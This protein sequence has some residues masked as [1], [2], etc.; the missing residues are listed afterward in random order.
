MSAPDNN[1]PLPSAGRQV[2]GEIEDRLVRSVQARYAEN[3]EITPEKVTEII[4]DGDPVEY[5]GWDQAAEDRMLARWEASPR[6]KSSDTIGTRR[7]NDNPLCEVWRLCL[8]FLKQA[9]PIMLSPI[10]GLQFTGERQT[11]T[12]SD[13]FTVAAC[14]M[15]SKLFVHPLWRGDYRPF[16]DAL[17]FAA[18]CRVGGKAN[19]NLSFRWPRSCPVIHA[20]NAKLR[21]LTKSRSPLPNTLQK[22]H[23]AARDNVIGSGATES[24]FSEALYH[25][26]K[27]ATIDEVPLDTEMAQ[28]RQGI[29]PFQV[30]DLDAIKKALDEM[31]S[32]SNRFEGSVEDTYAVFKSL[33]RR[34]QIP[35]VKQL[36]GLDAR[37]CR[38]VFRMSE[39]PERFGSVSL[40]PD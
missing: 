20:L 38:Q 30:K 36:R 9:P 35:S 14:Q 18:F 3:A 19:I 26:G 8:R 25:I 6:K 1:A 40:P 13:L 31:A 2:M 23:R 29:V 12:S 33:G 7:N 39:M 34:G 21:E 27:I 4:G 10:N 16:V 11:K 17:I 5:D 32:S 37:A 15:I 28:I 22:L 24:L